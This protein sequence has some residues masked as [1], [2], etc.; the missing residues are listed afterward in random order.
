MFEVGF[1]ELLLICGLALIVLGPERL[2]KLAQQVGRWVGRAR[3]MARQLR[4]QLDQEVNYAADNRRSTSD[5]TGS[6]TAA[7][8]PSTTDASTTDVAADVDEYGGR[9]DNRSHNDAG[10][11]ASEVVES[12]P[13]NTAQTTPDC[14]FERNQRRCRPNASRTGPGRATA[15]SLGLTHEF[16]GKRP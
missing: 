15:R 2:P 7:S 8:E 4:D 11:E 3:A 12:E 6:G 16:R 13:A 1:T 14:L 9:H 5:K 10:A